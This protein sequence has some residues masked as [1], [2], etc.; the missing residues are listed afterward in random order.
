MMW[1]IPGAG[2]RELD[3]GSRIL[4]PGPKLQGPGSGTQGSGSRMLHPESDMHKIEQTKLN[5]C[6]YSNIKLTKCN[7]PKRYKWIQFRHNSYEIIYNYMMLATDIQPLRVKGGWDSG[8]QI[9][10]PCVCIVCP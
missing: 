4:D 3:L 5:K 7:A 6:I 1:W 2:V 10:D 9:L 8:S